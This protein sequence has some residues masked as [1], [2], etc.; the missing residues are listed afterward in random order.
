MKNNNHSRRQI[1]DQIEKRFKTIMIGSL[2][3][4]EK[5]FGYLWNNEEEPN[6]KQ[7]VYFREKWEELRNDLL[8][9]GN[10]QIRHGL[11]DLGRYLSSVEK[12][13]LQIFY[14][15]PEGDE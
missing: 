2:A 5:E 12:Y 13:N 9:H 8:D 11:Q 14:K 6:T 15:Q 3:R 7:E 4:F 1:M 10:N